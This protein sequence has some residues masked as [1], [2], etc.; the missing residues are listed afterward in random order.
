M[1]SSLASG[2]TWE[3]HQTEAFAKSRESKGC[4]PDKVRIH[5][6]LLSVDAVVADGAAGM[7]AGKSRLP[8]KPESEIRTRL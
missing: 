5:G 4:C 7:E 6:D 8:S 3:G 1:S 2:L